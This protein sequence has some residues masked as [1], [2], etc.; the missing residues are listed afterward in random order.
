MVA[1]S[2]LLPFHNAET[3]LEAALES[4]NSQNCEEEIEFILINDGSTDH[5]EDVVKYFFALHPEFEKKSKLIN[6]PFRQGVAAATALGI[7]NASGEFLARLDADDTFTGDSINTLLFKARENC[8]DIVCGKVNKTYP[9]NKVKEVAPSKHFG[10]LNNMPLDT[11]NFS[12]CNKLVRKSL[13]AD[14]NIMPMNGID[15]WEDVNI[16]SRAFAVAKKT[17]VVDSLVYNY[18]IDNRSASLS[19][20]QHDLAMR[21]RQMCSLLVEKWFVENG[22][23]EKYEKFILLMKF[24]AKIKL[25]RGNYCDISKWRET[26]PEVNK[27]IMYIT[28]LPIALRVSFFILDKLPQKLG[29]VI[30]EF[31][32][33]FV[34]R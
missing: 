13:L 16:I 3:T 14:N 9:G 26:Y 21:Q 28:Q 8:A 22:L 12:Q 31:A 24:H 6:S 15:C 2:V 18:T 5:S 23:V 29:Q 27:R 33:R 19:N 25:L 17:V 20:T 10:D 7:N 11:V 32:D 1:V 30:C 34:K 4:L